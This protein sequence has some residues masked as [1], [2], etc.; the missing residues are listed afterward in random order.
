MV[1]RPATYPAT[2]LICVPDRVP[3][4]PGIPGAPEVTAAA[5]C[6]ELRPRPTRFPPPAPWHDEQ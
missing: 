5:T 6:A 4:K 1:P 3:E 2:A